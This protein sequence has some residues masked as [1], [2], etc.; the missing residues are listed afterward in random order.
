MRFDRAGYSDDCFV[1]AVLPFILGAFT[2]APTSTGQTSRMAP[3][4]AATTVPIQFARDGWILI[5]AEVV[6]LNFRAHR[7]TLYR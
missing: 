5:P 2:A 7:F 3:P 4:P 6:G 1:A